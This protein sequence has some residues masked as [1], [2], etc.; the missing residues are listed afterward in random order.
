MR[1]FEY[2][3]KEL[4]SKYGIPV[5]RSNVADDESQALSAVDAVGLPAVIKAQVLSGGRGKAG[6]VVLVRSR[7]EA[8]TEAER[9]LSLRVGGEPTRALLVEEALEHGEEMYLSISLNRGRREFVALASRSGGTEVESLSEGGMVEVPVPLDGLSEAAASSLAAELG[10]DGRTSAEFRSILMK[11]ERLSREEES[12]LAEINPLA[13]RSDGT[14]VALD[15]KVVLDDNAL[16]RHP[17]FSQLPP[18]DPLEGEAAKFGFAFVRLDGNIAVVG[19]GAGL[20]L[21]T[22]DLVADAGGR[23][24]CFLDLGGG[25]QRERVEAALR[26]VRGLPSAKAVLVN[27]FGGI[28]RTTDVAEGLRDVISERPTALVFARISGAEEAEARALLSGSGVPVYGTAQEAV[29]AAV[30]GAKA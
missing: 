19:N 17:E 30:E 21:S 24:A 20:V 1:L 28:T 4:F 8:R 7:E 23:A 5:P 25:A 6:G 27:I 10:L 18:E 2:Q 15:S 3:G 16:F 29:L 14:L 12:E 26:M 11:L 13:V 22:L 9:I